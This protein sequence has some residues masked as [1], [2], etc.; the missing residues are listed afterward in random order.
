MVTPI[1]QWHGSV[2]PVCMDARIVWIERTRFVNDTTRTNEHFWQANSFLPHVWNDAVLAAAPLNIGPRWEEVRSH[3]IHYH[4]VHLY[5]IVHA[6]F[7]RH[8]EWRH[9]DTAPWDSRLR[10]HYHGR[11]TAWSQLHHSNDALSWIGYFW[12]VKN[13]VWVRLVNGKMVR[14]Y[15]VEKLNKV[16]LTHWA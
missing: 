8:R 11:S 9:F 6:I 5:G 12:E 2:C 16:P 10:G 14:Q 15:I 3:R 7:A 1:L 4:D 13:V